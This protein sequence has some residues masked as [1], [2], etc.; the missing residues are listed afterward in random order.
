M[1]ELA[2]LL[3]PELEMADAAAARTAR[4]VQI[5]GRNSMSEKCQQRT[6]APQQ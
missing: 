4:E 3:K 1:R 2:Q 6:H 5:A